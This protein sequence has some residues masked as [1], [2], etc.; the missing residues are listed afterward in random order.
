MIKKLIPLFT[1]LDLLDKPDSKRRIHVIPTPRGAGVVL[2]ITFCIVF[3]LYQHFFNPIFFYDAV[4]ISF[5]LFFLALISFID[6]IKNISVLIRLISHYVSSCFLLYLYYDH[7]FFI[8]HQFFYWFIF[9]FISF[10]LT[11]LINIFNFL[12]GIDGISAA[13]SIHLAITLIVLCSLRK[14][15]IF[16]YDFVLPII[17]IILGFSFSFIFFNWYPAKIFL[18]DVGSISLGF[19]FSLIFLLVST[20]SYELF[21]SLFIANLYYL[22]DGFLTIF[23][24]LC[25]GQKIWLPHLE[26]FFQQAVKRG[27]SHSQVVRQVMIC[28]IILMILSIACLQ[29]KITLIISFILSIVIVFI[30]LY[31]FFYW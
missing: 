12:D 3:P 26:H 18:G 23:R 13:Q 4:K 21:I 25:K 29:G 2:V 15:I 22:S 19:L 20:N 17:V 30:T 27:K 7:L 9:F 31:R 5:L 28:N 14:N 11:S 6:D 24:R 16:Y 10:L 8:N 1:Y